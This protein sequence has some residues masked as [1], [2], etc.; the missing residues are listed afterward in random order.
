MI[1]SEK[2]KNFRDEIDKTYDAVS[3]C[4]IILDFL[5]KNN[6]NNKE[7]YYLLSI[8]KKES[9]FF[10]LR[11]WSRD[12][13]FHVTTHGKTKEWSALVE[14]IQDKAVEAKK[15]DVDNEHESYFVEILSEH[16][17]TEWPP[18]TFLKTQTLKDYEREKAK[19]AKQAEVEISSLENSLL[20]K[21][22]NCSIM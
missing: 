10:E 6:L 21:S 12:E 20:C 16:K 7:L 17:V 5:D 11:R 8:L 2:F 4:G 14:K 13:F 19:E 18:F 15:A 3:M 1:L 22:G 9:L